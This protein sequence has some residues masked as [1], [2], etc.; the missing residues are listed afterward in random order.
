MNGHE[1]RIK[2]GD[3]TMS[4]I[5][6]MSEGNPGAMST[7][8]EIIS[9]N[10]EIDPDDLMQGFGPILHLDSIGIYGTDIYILYNDIC[11]RDITE[12]LA[13]L[14]SVQLGI[15]KGNIL[16]DACHRQDRSGKSM[17]PVDELYAKVKEMLPNF[18]S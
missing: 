9:K 4:A 1:E 6:K 14:R 13:V 2:L 11:E 3:T 18:N 16:K 5:I 17:V 15:F 12:T 7:L 10:P 8:M